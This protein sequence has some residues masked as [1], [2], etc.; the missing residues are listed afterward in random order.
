MDCRKTQNMGLNKMSEIITTKS[1]LIRAIHHFNE[2]HDIL[3]MTSTCQIFD[4]NDHDCKDCPFA[5][6]RCE[7]LEKI[8][9][10]I[11]DPLANMEI[12]EC[13]PEPKITLTN[14][15]YTYEIIYTNKI[16]KRTRKIYLKSDKIVNAAT[17]AMKS[18]IFYEEFTGI[19]KLIG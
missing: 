9:Q 5:G 15:E 3:S 4:E 11:P 14:P 12:I 18:K 7:Q 8:W 1:A 6:G 13:K 10:S 16:T 19:T 2:L 17:N